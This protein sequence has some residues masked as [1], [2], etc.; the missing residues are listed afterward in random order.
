MLTYPLTLLLQIPECLQMAL[1]LRHYAEHL[2]SIVTYLGR[3]YRCQQQP[4]QPFHRHL[5]LSWKA[6][7]KV[8]LEYVLFQFPTTETRTSSVNYLTLKL[9]GGHSSEMSVSL[10]QTTRRHVPK[11]STLHRNRRENIEAPIKLI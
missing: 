10:Y 2:V 5:V 11:D 6:V 3:H 4:R 7:S 1:V 8:V 9:E